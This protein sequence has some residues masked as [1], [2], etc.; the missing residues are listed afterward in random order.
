[1]KRASL[2]Y[3]IGNGTWITVNMTNVGGNVWNATIP[4]FPYG[5][6][7]TYVIKA[8]DNAGNIVT[9][10]DLGYVCKYQV[11]PEYPTILILPLLIITALLTVIFS[12]KKKLVAK[13]LDARDEPAQK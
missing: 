9:S 12:K 4:A 8:E 13:R 6:N 5:T 11:I 7:V 1:V 3:T 10:E 2:N